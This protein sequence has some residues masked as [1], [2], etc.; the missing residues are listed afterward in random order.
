MWTAIAEKQQPS[1][2]SE[3]QIRLKEE[4]KKETTRPTLC[5]F[6][7]SVFLDGRVFKLFLVNHQFRNYL[8]SALHRPTYQTTSLQHS[9]PPLSFYKVWV[10]FMLLKSS[11]F[12]SYGQIEGL[13]NSLWA[14]ARKKTLNM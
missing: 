1:A 12:L 10:S 2:E 6:S 7:S 14:V 5:F 13:K 8:I 3:P 9:Q 4:K 11:N